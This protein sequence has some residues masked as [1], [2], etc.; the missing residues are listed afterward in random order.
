MGLLR[1][2]RL[3]AL[4]LLAQ[5]SIGHAA[6]LVASSETTAF[7]NE[8]YNAFA[9]AGVDD[10]CELIWTFNRPGEFDFACLIAGHYEA[11]MAGKITVAAR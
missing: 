9:A 11:G 1:P 7:V 3:T 2:C 10:S 4:A 6:A 5:V 8:E